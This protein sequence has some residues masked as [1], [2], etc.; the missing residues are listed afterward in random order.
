MKPEAL[1]L[2]RVTEPSRPESS[3]STNAFPSYPLPQGAWKLDN[4]PKIL[5]E[6]ELLL[7]LQVLELDA[8]SMMN[9]RDSVSARNMTVS[10]QILN[11]VNS[12]GKMHNP[13]TDSGGVC[14][15]MVKSIGKNAP[16]RR[17]VSIGSRVIPLCSLSAIPISLT[18]IFDVGKSHSQVSVEGTAVIFENIK[19]AV[20]PNQL[21][22]KLAL[23]A[24]DISRLI[25]Q[26]HSLFKSLS[27]FKLRP[28]SGKRGRTAVVV[29]CG[30]SGLFALAELG[31]LIK[32]TESEWRLLGI[33][34]SKQALNVARSLNCTHG[35]FLC[36]ALD[37]R[38]IL[39]VRTDALQGEGADLVLNCV[40]VK[41]TEGATSVLLSPG[42]TIVYFS[43]STS[44]SK[45]VLS[46]DGVGIPCTVICG[47]GV[48]ENQASDAF[49]ALQHSYPLFRWCGLHFGAYHW[50]PT[51][52]QVTS[53]SIFRFTKQYLQH[54]TDQLSLSAF[55]RNPYAWYVLKWRW[56]FSRLAE[57]KKPFCS[58]S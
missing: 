37:I 4:A 47:A 18:A 28:I 32:N 53:S 41:G 24:V 15:G 27:S 14:V 11:I 42:G 23:A 50:V 46:T 58:I 29:G 5:H 26:V 25:P 57:A 54:T 48:Y 8:T 30:A 3:L 55:C 1:G 38:D 51:I 6:T 16:C 49:A 12:R 19:L 7:D 40:N 35:L 44:F 17:D 10:E 2:H 13:E 31:R 56:S 36:N 22:L 33:D 9:L 45:A 21:P 20:V 52:E 39:R 34:A 43:M